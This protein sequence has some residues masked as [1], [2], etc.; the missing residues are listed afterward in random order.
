MKYLVMKETTL[1]SQLFMNMLSK[2]LMLFRSFAHLVSFSFVF[3]VC[4]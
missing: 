3:A 2:M 1:K 4:K